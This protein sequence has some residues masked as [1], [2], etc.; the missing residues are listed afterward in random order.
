MSNNSVKRFFFKL[1]YFL[2]PSK[3]YFRLPYNCSNLNQNQINALK[4]YILFPSIYLLRKEAINWVAFWF[5]FYMAYIG[6]LFSKEQ[7]INWHSIAVIL[8]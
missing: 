6:Y 5:W 8:R 4:F 3:N 7:K 1:S 2:F